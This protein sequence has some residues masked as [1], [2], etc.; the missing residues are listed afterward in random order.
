MNVLDKRSLGTGVGAAVL[1]CA[2]L[3]LVLPPYWIYLAISAAISAVIMLSFGVIVGRAGVI[4]LCQMSFAAI[5]AWVMLRLNVA[6]APGGFYLWL[7]LGGLAAVPVGVAIGLPALRI[8]GV[9]L[10]V[11]TFGFAVSTDIVLNVNEF[12]GAKDLTTLDRPAPF[13]T[14]GGYFVFCMIVFTVLALA[15]GIIGRTRLGLSWYE[16]RHSER[17]AA[18][19]GIS[20]AR[21]KLAAFAISAFVAGIGGGL[22]AGQLSLVVPQNFAMGQS[23]ALFAVAVMIGPHHP[24]GAVI[25]GIFGAIMGTIMEKISLPQDFGGVLFG[26][27]ALLALRSGLSHTDLTR[28]RKREAGARKMLKA[29][30]EKS[31]EET[32]AGERAA[33]GGKAETAVAPAAV[34]APR[35]AGD[36]PPLLTVKGL[37]VKFGEVVALGGVDLTVPEGGVVGLIGPNGAGKSTFIAAVSGFVGYQ[38]AVELAGRPLDR[39]SP[40]KRATLG[41]RRTFQTTA[42]AP[43]LTQYE[44]LTIGAGRRLTRAEADE[45]L[46][47]FGCPPGQ[48]PVSIVDAGSRRLL[49]VAAAIAA[50]P[51]VALLDEPA[52][53]QSAAESLALGARLTAVPEAFGVSILLVEH[54]MELVQAVCEQVT[55]LDFGNVIA[56]GP[57]GEVLEDPAVRAAYLGAADV[58]AS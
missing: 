36:R 17:S 21:S 40:N 27:G 1:A 34:P 14:D 39:L 18:A 56:S 46:E 8:R 42:I 55:V 47:F 50:R 53:G 10:A 5:G 2:V 30:E 16:L 45:L 49:D 24:E 31:S 35:P 3:P 37:T 43:E 57:T 29:A 4:S 33:G 51:K 41:L 25:G 19:H 20:V 44:Y 58:P 9:N 15:L 38:G 48:V 28:M 52:A 7:L 54:D 6:E 23:L 22:L 12:P 26:V 11:V 13:D 32:P